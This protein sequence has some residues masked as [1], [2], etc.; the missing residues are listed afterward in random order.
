M[1]LKS[2]GADPPS[3]EHAMKGSE[4]HE[5]HHGHKMPAPPTDGTSAASHAHLQAPD[6]HRHE[7]GAH[8]R[9]AGH[10]VEMF[11]DRFSITLA[12]TIPTLVW[13][14]MI[15]EWFRFRAP[16]FPGSEYI[17][18]VFGTAVYLYGGWV[19]LAG[20]LRELRDR[21]PGMMT[22]ISLAIS[23]AFFF[24][25][26]VTLGYPGDALWW[27]LATLVAIMLLGHWIEMRSIFQASGAVREL[28]KLLPSTAQRIVG[29]RIEDVPISVLK[30]TD[31]VLVR[32][33]ASIPADGIVRDGKS[34]IN[35]SMLTGESVPVPRGEG[36]RGDGQWRRL[37]PR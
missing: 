9:H 24:S 30:E 20:G 21:L 26:A 13:S 10:S 23:V 1:R 37:T 11:R 18:A 33:G 15:Q 19:F 31:L 14:D 8:D 16:T 29:D 27:E 5:H 2:G 4:M 35:E 22:L 25:L 12:L 28:A 7:P 36:D 3:L 6:A 34:D 17:P 32:P